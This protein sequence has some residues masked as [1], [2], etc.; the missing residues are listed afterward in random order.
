MNIGFA[1]Y[2]RY[3]WIACP[4]CG[5]AG[6]NLVMRAAMDTDTDTETD[7]CAGVVQ[8]CA[9]D[10]GCGAEVV[11][12]VD[13]RLCLGAGFF[14][15]PPDNRRLEWLRLPHLPHAHPFERI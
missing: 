7:A 15:G 11:Q 10:C 2:M 9:G 1:A 8:K 5:G 6:S 3:K 4:G 12:S 13:C 14:Q